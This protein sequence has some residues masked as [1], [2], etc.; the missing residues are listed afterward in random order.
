M[1]RRSSA[2]SAVASIIDTPTNEIIIPASTVP[3]TSYIIS[4]R[5]GHTALRLFIADIITTSPLIENLTSTDYARIAEVLNTYADL[6]LDFVNASILAI[7]ERINVRR[8]LTLDRRDFSVLRPR[9][10]AYLELL[11]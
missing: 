11:P 9:H 2:H 6:R 10:C 1:D 5:L 8:V 3:E 7:A 4:S